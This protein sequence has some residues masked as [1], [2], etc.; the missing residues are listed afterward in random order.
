MSTRARA[1]RRSPRTRGKSPSA[2]LR[3]RSPAQFAHRGLPRASLPVSMKPAGMHHAP[4]RWLDPALHEQHA[5]VVHDQHA[6]GG[7]GIAV[8]DERARSS[9]AMTPCSGAARA[10]W[11]SAGNTLGSRRDMARKLGAHARRA[12]HGGRAR[13]GSATRPFTAGPHL[14]IVSGSAALLRLASNFAPCATPC[15]GR[16]GR[17]FPVMRW[18]RLPRRVSPRWFSDANPPAR[19]RTH[20]PARAGRRAVPQLAV[21][22]ARRHGGDHPSVSCS[23]KAH[24]RSELA[25]FGGAKR[26]AVLQRGL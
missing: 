17:R 2:R 12:Q 20:A 22:S 23:A 15:G 6:R 11:R 5:R 8:P 26:A 13:N 18:V 16:D 24:P 21:R 1:G 7:H 9:G 10:Q 14:F 19:W 4:A 25:S 3:G